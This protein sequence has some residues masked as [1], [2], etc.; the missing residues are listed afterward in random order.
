MKET[1]R[2][3]QS[4]MMLIYGTIILV[5]GLIGTFFP[6]SSRFIINFCFIFGGSSMLT[7]LFYFAG[8]KMNQPKKKQKII[9]KERSTIEKQL[10]SIN[11]N[12][13]EAG[14]GF[15]RT[16]PKNEFLTC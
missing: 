9:L 6:E 4:K 11:E 14:N 8:K 12:L 13:Y 7:G 2:K 15:V 3:E 1:I 10:C 16:N 5:L